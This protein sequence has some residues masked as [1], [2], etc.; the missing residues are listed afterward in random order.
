MGEAQESRRLPRGV[1]LKEEVRVRDNWGSGERPPAR[2]ANS[3]QD[4]CLVD[5]SPVPAAGASWWFGFGLL[6]QSCE[7]VGKEKGNLFRLLSF[8]VSAGETLPIPR[9]EAAKR[10]PAR[11]ARPFLFPSRVSV[12]FL[13]QFLCGSSRQHLPDR[14]LIIKA[15]VALPLGEWRCLTGVFNV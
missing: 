7:S 1:R 13:L 12:Q 8:P 2:T 6:P 11:C 5:Y 14:F 9:P 4:L 10:D 3:Y 15:L